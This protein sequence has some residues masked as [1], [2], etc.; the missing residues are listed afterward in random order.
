MLL[1]MLLTS[2][3]EEMAWRRSR[4]REQSGHKF[5]EACARLPGAWSRLGN[6]GWYLVTS[7]RL[8]C[9][10]LNDSAVVVI[11]RHQILGDFIERGP[12][13][14]AERMVPYDKRRAGVELFI[15]QVS[16]GEL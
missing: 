12:V 5:I 15:L 16:A 6:L 14:L 8:L 1:I 3:S 7:N 9:R 13:G 4:S 2:A 10:D 11:A